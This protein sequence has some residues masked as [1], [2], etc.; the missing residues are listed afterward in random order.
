M[1]TQRPTKQELTQ[2]VAKLQQRITRLERAYKRTRDKLRECETR[3]LDEQ[4]Y[5]AA[6]LRE[7]VAAHTVELRQEKENMD[8][9]ANNARDGIL[10]AAGAGELVF[11][12]AHAAEITGYAIS[13]L[14]GTMLQNLAVPDH[15]ALMHERYLKR[16][17]GEQ[18]PYQYEIEIR[19]RDGHLV[20][21]EITGAKTTWQNHPADLVLLRD[22]SER[23]QAEATLEWQVQVNA[24]MADLA[25]Q[26][27]SSLPTDE[28][29][30]L[31]LGYAK[32][33]TG[34]AYGF[35]GFIDPVTGH[36][37]VPTMTH[38]IWE[39]CKVENKTAV[40]SEFGG[41][42]G[43]VLQHRQSLLTND[44]AHD[45]RASGTPPGH[46]PIQ[47][48][49][50]APAMIGD[51]LVGQI[52]LANA[53][54][55][56]TARDLEVVERLAAM[57]ALTIQQQRTIQA[58]RAE[59][60]K[61]GTLFNIIPIGISMVDH[62]RNVV[63]QNPALEK[64]LALDSD[65]LKSGTFRNRQYLQSDG[66]PVSPEILPS[67]RA[68]RDQI[69][70]RDFEIG[71]VKENGETIWTNVSA[72][73]LPDG[74][75]V[76]VTADIT[77]RKAMEN[78]LRQ[79]RDRL[80]LLVQTRTAELSAAN[81]KLMQEMRERE[82][83]HAI[84]SESEQRYQVLFDGVN[85]AVMV[86]SP[87]R[88]F[89]DCNLAATE[90]L[91]Y[92]RA[93]FLQLQPADIV[94]PDFYALMREN[95]TNLQHGE[96]TLV[97]SVHR[98]KD[99]HAIPVQVNSRMIEYRGEHAMLSVVR[100]ITEHKRIEKAL[101]ESE[102]RYRLLA[103]HATDFIWTTDMQN[104]LTYAS[105]AVKLLL[106][107]SVEQAMSRSMDET[108]TPA[109]QALMGRVLAEE[110]AREADAQAPLQRAR[111]LELEMYH[112]DGHVV[113][114]E[115]N[116]SFLRAAD[117]TPNGILAIARDITQ[118]KQMQQELRISLAKYQTL[119]DAF[120]LGI[121]VA[122]SQGNIIETNREAEHILRVP[123]HE[124]EQRKIG[125]DVWQIVRPDGTLMPPDEFASTRALREQ[126]RIENVE[127]GIRHGD[128]SVTWLNVT[129]APIEGYGVVAVYNDITERLAT[130]QALRA[131]EA[132][133][134]A[135][136]NATDDSIFLTEPTGTL[137]ALND[138]GAERLGKTAQEMLGKNIYD[139]VP[140]E[141]ISNRRAK[142]QQVIETK[143]YVSFEDYR[144]TRW[145]DNHINP[146]LDEQ[147]NVVRLAIFGRD[148]TERKQMEL[149]LRNSES[150]YKRLLETAEEGIWMIDN[151]AFT[152]YVNPK[153]A[154]IL[155][156][157]PEEM[158]GRHLF[159]FMDEEGQGLAAEN[160]ER[161]RHGIAEQHD[162]KFQRQDGSAVWALL[163]TNPI[164]D[165]NGNFVGALAMVTDITERRANE[166]A[167]RESEERYRSL[168][169]MSP[170][171]I[172]VH[173]DGKFIYANPACA[174][175]FGVTAAQELI[176]V[177][178]LEFVHP[179]SCESV[180]ARLHVIYAEHQAPPLQEQK[181]LRTD[182]QIIYAEMSSIPVMY[183]GQ[184]AGQVIFRDITARKQVADELRVTRDTLQAVINASPLAVLS[185]DTQ[186]HIAMWNPAAEEM[187]GWRADEILGQPNFTIPENMEWEYELVQRAISKGQG[188][189]NF[190]TVRQCQDGRLLQVSLSAAALQ[191]ASGQ[192]YG[193]M[194][195]IAD[196]SARKQI[197]N[198]LRENQRLL[199]GII[200]YTP[201]LVYVLDVDGR[202]LLAN[203]KLEQIMYAERGELIGKTRA[204][205]LP[206]ALAAQHRSNDLEVMHSGG[207]LTFEEETM[208]ADGKHYFLTNK[209]PLRNAQD[210]ITAV[211][212]I[213]TD[214]TER[215]EAE[216]RLRQYS[217]DLAE[218][219]EELKRF[220]YIV[221]HD[222]RAPL[223]NL[224]GFA[225]ELRVSMQEI[226]PATEMGLQQL[227][228]AQRES[229]TL[230]LDKDIPE[231]LS[232]IE[233]ATARMDHFISALLKL[234]R[235]GRREF[236][237]EMTDMNAIVQATLETL[238]HQI[239]ARGVNVLVQELP[240]VV[241]DRVA[242]EQIMGNIL[243]NAVLYLDPQRAGEIEIS[244][245]RLAHETIYHV[246]DNGRG[247]APEDMDKVFAPFRRAGKPDVPG[248]GMGLAY[249][250]TLVRRHNG[251]IWCSSQP[252]QGSVFSFAIANHLKKESDNE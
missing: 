133:L 52:S 144:L 233:S 246:R 196:I 219:N 18:I 188:V 65:A 165:E 70:V 108:F 61:L 101:R 54:R 55:D 98:H 22:I 46:I 169:E 147:G 234:S 237:F 236:N 81:E 119:F 110:I 50:S 4:S 213:S 215:K 39:E 92:T 74:G 38:E 6:Q 149:T 29:A 230:A 160:L 127:M 90:R 113:N 116:F 167:L 221:S 123:K 11:A 203:R 222:L 206:D 67:V 238:A 180:Q 43:W 226:R 103:E 26:L 202:F 235:L 189:K 225:G 102:A 75:A 200:D 2:E 248:E 198:A 243:S 129:A 155:G 227:D 252:G 59:Q 14:L 163:N 66:T 244:G 47:R 27:L 245:E 166:Q 191:D 186:D 211:C 247:I 17:A 79:H 118:R 175:M 1:K 142:V 249:V 242:M 220:T 7:L 51:E 72:A 193:R 223:V 32:Q 112:H 96:N 125:G 209:F 170:E 100:D 145:I 42:W 9:L 218:S 154:K 36:L 232:F 45:A 138:I 8:A 135:L 62:R 77:A 197:E 35:V 190:E 164:Q 216:E 73:P 105:P 5:D 210:E 95:Q 33:L 49:V 89:V 85:D 217:Q 126:R 88:G 111:L 109:S 69:E 194:Q 15:Q 172:A 137:L 68:I 231:A 30:S 93:E 130:Q 146:V 173:R 97:E 20:P 25:Q 208:Q 107:F 156:Y 139:F 128:A 240:T 121:T 141:V 19:H 80:E 115:V 229:V 224:K 91:G 184:P 71:I 199:Q 64:I 40:F 21:V 148:I 120:P 250:Q 41:L 136:L 86:Y 82:R 228:E 182:G 12:N 34:S 177:P 114:V 201:S 178:L 60:V 153:M 87:A 56:Y 157:A 241:A 131:H 181:L 185:L 122:D 143:Q 31:V 162:F 13:E 94:H 207:T 171:P 48:F 158:Q 16:V 195:I 83:A 204:G 159:T 183:N 212:G 63:E 124:H 151:S 174:T 10:I 117:G 140:P 205:F 28:I 99:G 251:H 3:N 192:V 161:R 76:L 58:L 134:R 152:T 78:E 37:I 104:Q 24:A 44:A 214:I 168:V 84:L 179:D 150:S 57:Y 23:K 53:P 132:S 176:G 187:F 239:D 106:G